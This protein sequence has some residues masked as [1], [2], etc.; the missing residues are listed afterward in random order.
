MRS[1]VAD[2]VLEGL[3]LLIFA[4]LATILYD[5]NKGVE[6]LGGRLSV[7]SERVQ[8]YNEQNKYFRA[9]ISENSKRILAVER[10]C[11]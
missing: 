7:V 2:K 3:V 4:G 11:K 1:N 8:I 5:L 9:V 6:D 10:G